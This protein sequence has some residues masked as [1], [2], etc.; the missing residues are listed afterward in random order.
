MKITKERFNNIADMVKLSLIKEEETKLNKDLNQLLDFIE[1]MNE[2]DTDDVVPMD[3][4]HSLR[5]VYR[6]DIATDLST[7]EEEHANAPD[8]MDGYYVVPRILE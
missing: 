6:E 8:F 3:Y 7:K 1:T 5:N 2:I 4:V